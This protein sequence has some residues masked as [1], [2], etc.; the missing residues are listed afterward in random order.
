[1]I[2]KFKILNKLKIESITCITLKSKKGGSMEINNKI[3]KV[4]L[5]TNVDEL[6]EICTK[7]EDKLKEANT[8]ADELAN[9]EVIVTTPR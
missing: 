4:K 5:E 8:L 3:V 1:L 7:L 6:K 9:F 2:K